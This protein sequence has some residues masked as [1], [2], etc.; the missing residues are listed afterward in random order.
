MDKLLNQLI[1]E[2]KEINKE[3]YSSGSYWKYKNDKTIYQIKKKSLK[4]FRGINS[5]VGTSF[6]DNLVYD[7]RNEHN[8]KGRM[9]SFFYKLPIVSKIYGNQLKMTSKHISNLLKYQSIIFQKDERVKYLLEKYT[10]NNTTEFGCVQKFTLQNEEYSCLYLEMAN[11]VEEI[12]K[13]INFKSIKRYL[14]IG[15][16]FGANIH[17]LI[18]NYANIKKI[19]YIDTVPNLYVGTEYLR[20]FYKNSIIDYTITKKM[21]EI[22]FSNNEELEIFCIPPWQIENL[23]IE[24]DHFH[25]AASFVEMPQKVVENYV[26]YIHLNKAKTISLVSY[27]SYDPKT[28]FDPKMLNKFFNNELETYEFP[29][30]INDFGKKNIYLIKK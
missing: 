17:F 6:S 27:G 7:V 30:I 22:K 11:R 13:Y 24:I 28:T 5:G 2:E 20:T 19:I 3:L 10:F 18:S 15:G 26:K 14:E 1:S 29:R 9:A 12:S 25:N 8:L 21:K 16:G 4:N 23:N